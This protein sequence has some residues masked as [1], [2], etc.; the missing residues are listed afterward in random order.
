MRAE[1]AC[2]GYSKEKEGRGRWKGEGGWKREITG[3]RD[4]KENGRWN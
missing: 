1:T 4:W 2:T 3:K